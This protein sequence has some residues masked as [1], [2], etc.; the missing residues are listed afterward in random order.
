MTDCSRFREGVT[1]GDR[2]SEDDLDD[3]CVTAISN[4]SPFWAVTDDRFDDRSLIIIA[5]IQERDIGIEA[6]LLVAAL[7]H[8]EAPCQLRG[9]GLG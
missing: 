5:A 1:D 6:G 7:A 8:R 2:F 4:L 3:R 9:E